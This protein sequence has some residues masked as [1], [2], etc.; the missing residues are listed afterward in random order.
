MYGG[1]VGMTN[2]AAPN[3]Q[4]KFTA[5]N[6]YLIFG[7][8]GDKS[9]GTKY[10]NYYGNYT[11][12][13]TNCVMTANGFKF[14][15]DKANTT[16]IFENTDLLVSGVLMTDDASSTFTFKNCKVL[17]KATSNGSDDKNQNAGVMTLLN[18]EF[19]YNAKFTNVGT[20]NIDLGSLL[21]A[22]EIVGKGKIVVDATGFEGESLKLI[23]GD[24]TGF[25]GTVEVTGAAY[26]ITAEG[27][28]IVANS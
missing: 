21:S 26:E 19:T 13:I 9:F 22:P 24:M 10:G 23:A 17:S 4:N 14:Y 8:Q 1:L 2:S 6:A 7:V 3:A 11:F 28:F 25:T 27:L 5:K 12:E 20:L 15:E 18:T 16:L